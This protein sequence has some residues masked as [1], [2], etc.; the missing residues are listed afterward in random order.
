[1]AAYHRVDDL[2]SPAGWLL[3]HWDQL[4]A[5]RSVSSMG[6]LY[7][8]FFIVLC[9]RRPVV[10]DNLQSGS[11]RQHWFR[12]S[13]WYL[14]NLYYYTGWHKN[15]LCHCTCM[16]C[17]QIRTNFQN[18]FTARL[19]SKLFI[20]LSLQICPYLEHV[21]STSLWSTWHLVD[22]RR[23]VAGAFVPTCIYLFLSL[24]IFYSTSCDR[25]CLSS[26]VCRLHLGIQVWFPPSP[27]LLYKSGYWHWR[28][29]VT[30]NVGQCP[31]WWPPYRI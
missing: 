4:R 9:G 6:S 1:M 10:A 22:S 16:Y 31:T 12:E 20:N 11:E 7:L 23:L 26:W 5:Q 2:R 15:C 21:A 14:L 13:G 8:Y 25:P 3:V 28:T 29:N 17:R 18:P 24:V 30:S 27:V 19:G